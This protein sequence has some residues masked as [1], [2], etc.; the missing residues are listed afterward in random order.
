LNDMARNG[1][2]NLIIVSGPSGAGK[3]ALVANVM[4]S[5]PHLKFSVSFTTR[6]PRGAEQDGVEYFFVDRPA[7][8]SLVH[9]DKL[10]EWAE[11]H[12]NFYGTSQKLVEDS[13]REGQDV[14]LDIDVQGASI[15]RKKRAD[16]IAVFIL[17]PSY[18]VLR[19]RLQKRSLDDGFV[20]EQR[21]KKAWKEV[22]HYIDYDYLI[23]NE[24]LGNSTHELESIILGARCRMNARIESAKSVLATFGGID[25]E[26]P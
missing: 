19:T 16:S 26:D 3:S 4:R 20:I 11:V 21:L 9:E 18:Q 7:F 2:G 22:S 14:L 10:L 12:G 13:L 5:V 15:V 8:Q 1:N 6:A 24:D 23:I 25:A 17:P